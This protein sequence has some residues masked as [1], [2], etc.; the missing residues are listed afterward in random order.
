ML[1]KP[2]EIGIF[3]N[4][5]IFGSGFKSLHLRHKKSPVSSGKL[6]FFFSIV[7]HKITHF[8]FCVAKI[9]PKTSS[10]ALVICF[11]IPETACP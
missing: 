1:K 2:L 8:Y 3:G 9:P 6:G 4:R 5:S 11:S 7:T 10:R